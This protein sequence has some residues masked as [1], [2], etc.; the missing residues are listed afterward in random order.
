VILINDTIIPA[1]IED[2]TGQ[3]RPVIEGLIVDRGWTA[4]NVRA[5]INDIPE[6][7]DLILVIDLLEQMHSANYPIYLYLWYLPIVRYQD[8]EPESSSSQESIIRT[9]L[10]SLDVDAIY[11]AAAS[12]YMLE[13][14]NVINL[15]TADIILN[16]PEVLKDINVIASVDSVSQYTAMMLAHSLNLKLIQISNYINNSSGRVIDTEILSGK[17]NIAGRDI[18]LVGDVCYKSS[19]YT[20]SAEA[21]RH[22]SK[23]KSVSMFTTH[24]IYL[25]GID[26][27]DKCF[28]NI[29]TTDS[30]YSQGGETY[31]RVTEVSI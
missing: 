4:I 23:Y 27:L 9:L 31:E 5:T 3:K 18:L 30:I 21:M 13:L 28:K 25:D 19:L 22:Q 14:D 11:L 7:L 17:T 24:G 26:K 12:S 1:F 20:R 6:L 16:N 10:G 29:Y 8:E 15:S 2:Y